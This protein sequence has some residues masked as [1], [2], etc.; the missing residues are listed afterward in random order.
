M[1]L[2]VTENIPCRRL[3]QLETIPDE[4]TFTE[5]STQLSE[6]SQ[7]KVE[8]AHEVRDEQS[9]MEVPR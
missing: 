9:I 1:R 4:R 7:E 2:F 6:F 3:M 8:A 5:S